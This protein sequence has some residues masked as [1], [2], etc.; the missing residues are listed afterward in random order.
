MRSAASY[1]KSSGGEAPTVP[2]T[3]GVRASRSSTTRSAPRP[4]GMTMPCSVQ[5]RSRICAGSRAFSRAYFLLLIAMAIFALSGDRRF[6][7][8]PVT[9]YQF[10]EL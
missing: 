8:V 3:S 5:P 9:G 6:A 4:S 10:V 7:S 2:I 1:G